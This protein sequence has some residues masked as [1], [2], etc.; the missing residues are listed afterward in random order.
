[1]D[2]E[3]SVRELIRII[4][5][6]EGYQ[7]IVA[8][9]GP[10]ALKLAGDSGT[11]DILITDILMPVMNGRELANR[12]SANAPDLKVL[13]ISAYSAEVLTYHHLC[14]DKADLIR[15]PFRNHILVDKLKDMLF[16]GYSWK[17]IVSKQA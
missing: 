7:V 3:K 9:N 10:E 2:D 14:P 13:F 6:K 17:E 15:K 16:S 12:M 5:E 4:L 8:A 11:F 1:M